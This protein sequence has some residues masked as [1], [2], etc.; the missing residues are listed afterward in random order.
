MVA[1]TLCILIGT[2]HRLVPPSTER[3]GPSVPPIV[4]KNRKPFS[5]YG[6]KADLIRVAGIHNSHGC[7]RLDER[8]NVD[9]DIGRYL[10][11]KPS[12]ILLSELGERLLEAARI[13]G[14]R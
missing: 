13:A 8:R 7:L 1:S 9:H 11:R 12:K 3:I 14:L 5:P 10:I 2:R 4:L 6:Q